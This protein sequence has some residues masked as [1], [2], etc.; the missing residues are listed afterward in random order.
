MVC[1]APVFWRPPIFWKPCFLESMMR[2]LRVHFLPG[3]LA[4]HDLSQSTCVVIDVLRATTTTVW[5]L[6]AGARAVV[7]C[8]TIDEARQ[9]AAA[10]AAGQA[11]LGGERGGLPI[12]GFDLG[13]SPAE[14]TAARVGGKTVVLTTTNGTKALL[15][16]RPAAQ[17]VLGAFVNLAAVGSVLSD[18]THVDVVC[19]GTNGQI[20][21]EDALLAGAIADLAAARD[22]WR[23]DDSAAIARDAWLNVTANVAGGDLKATL[24]EAMRASHGGRNLIQIGLERDIELAAEVDRFSIVPRFNPASGQIVAD[25]L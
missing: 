17:V 18:G 4:G 11:L 13:N 21:R 16:C 25:G 3:S 24:I 5:A 22:D 12:A 20:T 9:R 2:Q 6:A 7:P 15:Q 14:Y 10:F 23:L 1:V 8:L 19:A